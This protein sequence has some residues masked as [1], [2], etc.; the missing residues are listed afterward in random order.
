MTKHIESKN[1]MFVSD[2]AIRVGFCRETAAG[3]L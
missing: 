1:H 2:S 3:L